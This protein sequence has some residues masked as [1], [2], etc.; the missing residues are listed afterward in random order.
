MNRKSSLFFILILFCAVNAY[1]LPLMAA[2]DPVPTAPAPASDPLSGQLG[3]QFATA[4]AVSWVIQKLKA[5]GWFK[6]ITP[7]S[8]A[9]AQR[10]LSGILAVAAAAGI[11]FAF[12]KSGAAT[13]TYVITVTGLTLSNGLHFGWDAIQQFVLQHF[14]YHNGIKGSV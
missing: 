12:D 9:K 7:E 14:A 3:S 13:G 10:A 5:S 2:Q 1:A 11:H 6:W 4:A 8:S